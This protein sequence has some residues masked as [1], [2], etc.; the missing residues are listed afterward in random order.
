[1]HGT[2][3][4]RTTSRLG[5]VTAALT[6]A[7]ALVAAL[8]P[9][10]AAAATLTPVDS[11]RVLSQQMGEGA[12]VQVL[13]S[14]KADAALP[15]ETE[16]LIPKEFTFAKAELFRSDQFSD[17]AAADSVAEATYRTEKRGDDIAYIV[18]LKGADSVMLLFTA[19]AGIYQMPANGHSIAQ[20]GLVAPSDLSALEYGFVMPAGKVGTGS[21]V[22]EFGR[23]SEGAQIAGIA[24]TDVKKG[25]RKTAQLAIGEPTAESTATA[26]GATGA[27]WFKNLFTGTNLIIVG[28]V[29]AVL[30]LVGAG[31]FVITRR[32]AAA[33]DEYDNEFEDEFEG[34]EDAVAEADVAGADAAAE[35]EGDFFKD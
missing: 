29:V 9:A 11:M 23:T 16:V 19:P 3:L 4:S 8:A 21:N 28:L 14:V 22:V 10:T 25:E 31:A 34:D 13:A 30:V 18:T 33:A 32:G 6:L 5:A 2:T 24:F 17:T 15:T 1:M 35:D 26:G 7:L 27:S 12:L 20:L